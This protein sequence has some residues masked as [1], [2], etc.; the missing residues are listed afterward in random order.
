MDRM[1]Y[2]VIG[3]DLRNVK[4]AEAIVSDGN[5]VNLFGFEKAGFETTLDEIEDLDA[6]IDD[7]QIVIGPLPC[8]NDN[9]VLNTPF[10]KN[11]IYIN[12]VFRKMKK[13]QLFIAGRISDRITQM[14]KAYNVYTIDLLEREEMAVLNCIPTAEGAI[15]IAMEELPVTLN[16]S[17][18][19]ILG[20]GRL[21]KVLTRMLSGIGAEVWAE[22][23]KFS[24]LAWMK[25]NGIN[26]VHINDL[27]DYLGRMDVIYNTIPS[28]ILNS[29]R[30][31]K[32]GRE[33]LVIDL[34]SKPGGVDFD[35]AKLLG[36]KVIWALSLPGKV[37]PVTAANYMKQTIYNIIEELGV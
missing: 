32:L 37:A 6:A 3:G 31:E 13:N 24:D 28:R 33:C 12:E 23:R 25:A 15:Q 11:K 21:G 8:T 20:Y 29:D 5:Q 1:K 18:I 4:L 7:S 9:E 2:T 36:I 22:A 35:R 19:L 26:A 16:G 27:D 17:K 10:H 30:L 14:A 34:A